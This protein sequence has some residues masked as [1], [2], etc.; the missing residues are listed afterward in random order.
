MAV[1]FTFT[2]RLVWKVAQDNP[3]VANACS[4]HLAQS[5][6]YGRPLVVVAIVMSVRMAIVSVVQLGSYLE[7]DAYSSTRIEMGWDE[8]AVQLAKD[9]TQRDGVRHYFIRSLFSS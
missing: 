2:V 5:E 6:L 1:R 9:V 8:A 3:T 7:S 4:G